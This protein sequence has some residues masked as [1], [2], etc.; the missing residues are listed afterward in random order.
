MPQHCSCACLDGTSHVG[1]HLVNSQHRLAKPEDHFVVT[2][3][4]HMCHA[5]AAAVQQPRHA[6][7]NLF[8]SVAGKWRAVWQAV[9]QYSSGAVRLHLALFY[10]YGL[11]YHWSK[12]AT[13]EQ[14]L[15]TCL[16]QLTALSIT[17]R[18]VC[19][20]LFNNRLASVKL[21]Q[22]QYWQQRSLMSLEF[23]VVAVSPCQ[24]ALA[25]RSEIH[26]HWQ[27]LRASAK[28][29]SARG[30]SVCSACNNE[31]ILDHRSDQA[32]HFC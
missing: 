23:D 18:D 14:I 29:S 22:L 24:W 26:L 2:K 28:L 3:T 13:G 6:L 1:T 31:R 10:F 19:C 11:Y 5:G 20:L 27:D 30:A 32:A 25:C 16:F 12:R 7:Q 15:S 9:S 8:N 4:P 17:S 21:R